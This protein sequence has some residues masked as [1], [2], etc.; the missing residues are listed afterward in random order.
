LDKL[1]ICFETN[2]GLIIPIGFNSDLKGPRIIFLILSFSFV[3]LSIK[4]F[5][6]EINCPMSD[7]LISYEGL[8]AGNISASEV[9]IQISFFINELFEKAI[10]SN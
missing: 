8:R 6:K 3:F 7:L 10:S 1:K 9:F 4:F 2:S 5:L